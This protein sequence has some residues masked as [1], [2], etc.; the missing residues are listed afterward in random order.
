MN[1]FMTWLADHLGVILV[2]GLLVATVMF[3]AGVLATWRTAKNL[4]T[5]SR[6]VIRFL[7]S[8]M[9][10]VAGAGAIAFLA[11][12]L[13]ELGPGMWVQRDMLGKPAPSLEYAL[14]ESDRR[15]RL[16]DFRGRV[17]LVNVWAT[18][19]PPCLHEMADLDRLQRSYADQGLVVLHLSDEDRET[20]LAWLQDRQVSTVHAYAQPIPWPETG[21]P[22]TYVVDRDGTVQRV[23]LGQR[24]YD[25]FE[26]EILRVL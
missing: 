9:L 8:L 10:L 5:P 3:L 12:G 23:L 17:V 20:L 15:G 26:A 16:A 4:R 6:S 11:T 24:S 1:P 22:T 25:Q 7:L 18:W 19:C 2:G 21:R 14:V 13:V